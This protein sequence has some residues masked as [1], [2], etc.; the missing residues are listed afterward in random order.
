VNRHV[1]AA[2]VCS[3]AVLS[4]CGGS[5]RPTILNTEKV[6]RAIDQSIRQQR[7]LVS[8]S[9]CPSGTEQKKGLV[10][11]C[12]AVVKGRSYSVVVSETDAK[13]NV[14]YVVR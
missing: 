3:A 5:S 8:H 11:T 12:H 7:G 2:F 1:Y 14:T 10:F 9:S 6:E 4:G 13:G